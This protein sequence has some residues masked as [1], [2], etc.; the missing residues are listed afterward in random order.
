MSD[1]VLDNAQRRRDE[2]AAE[3]NKHNQKLEGLRKELAAVQIFINSWHH[4][5]NIRATTDTNEDTNPRNSP[6]TDH[7]H[8][9]E[10]VMIGTAF[11]GLLA[12]AKVDSP[13][14]PPP[15]TTR[16]NPDRA[17]VGRLAQQI[18]RERGKPVTR[19]ELMEA[20]NQRGVVIRGKNP[21]MV[22]S[23]MM[24]RMPQDFIR[25]AGH[26]YWLR[27][28][29]YLAAEYEGGRPPHL[30]DEEPDML[31]ITILDPESVSDA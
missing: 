2:I 8:L 25:L 10:D 11:A 23:T 13:P 3:I 12:N 18:I 30:E 28:L 17:E 29:P 15:K 16:K 4:F 7:G 31:Q 22:L 1:H 24:W 6:D 5:A 20:L 26:G 14:L 21:D 19:R 27:E 9:K